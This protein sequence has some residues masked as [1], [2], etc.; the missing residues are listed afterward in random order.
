MVLAEITINWER[1]LAR[2]ESRNL[3]AVRVSSGTRGDVVTTWFRVP[4][5]STIGLD[6]G[7]MVQ[8][9]PNGVE[10]TCSCEGGVSGR[11]CQHAAAALKAAGW[12]GEDAPVVTRKPRRSGL[13]AWQ[14]EDEADAHAAWGEP[15][16][17]LVMPED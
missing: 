11:P 10:V 4:S 16:A 14:D 1:A 13:L 2:A 15:F 3:A 5:W 17:D 8:A 6:H 7:V 9:G 12:L